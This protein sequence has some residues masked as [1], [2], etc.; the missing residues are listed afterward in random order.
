MK[1]L[2]ALL[3]DFGTKD[4]YVAVMKG[5][6]L[7]QVDNVQFVDITHDIDSGDTRCWY[8]IG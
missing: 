1:P 6:I 7:S 3:A 5:V 4:W 2:V 8:F